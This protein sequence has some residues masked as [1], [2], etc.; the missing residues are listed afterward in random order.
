[1]AALL[2]LSPQTRR[3]GARTTSNTSATR[4]NVVLQ[5]QTGYPPVN[6]LKM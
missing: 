2:N 4:P 6:G 1:M 5:K 3:G